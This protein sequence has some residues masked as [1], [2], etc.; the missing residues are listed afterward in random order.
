[1]STAGVEA[2][3]ALASS[4]QTIKRGLML[5]PEL[6][7]GIAGTVALSLIAMVGR[8]AVPIAVQQVIDKGLRAPGGP[9]LGIVVTIVSAA[10]VVLGITTTCSYLMMRR[11]FTVSETALA[12]VRTRTFRHIH[13]LSMLHQQ[14]ERR[15]TLTS[16]VTSDVDQI[17]QFLQFGGVILVV[18]TGQIV[19]TTAVMLFYSW[20]LALVV[21]IAFLP[22]SIVVRVFQRRLAAAYSAVRTRIGILLGAVSESVVGAE[23]IRAY[24]VAGRTGQRLDEAIENHRVAQTRALR[25]SVMS[26]SAGEIASGLAT[27][28]VVVIGV[29]LGVGGEIEVG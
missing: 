10:V 3:P 26:F 25:T 29:L 1:M 20:Q 9:N 2:E 18:N 14:S 16:R 13:D 11:L 7:V 23:V 8:V 15:G 28:S 21:Y 5:S 19:V 24:G 17:T 6:R 12:T 22:L 27:A 4:W